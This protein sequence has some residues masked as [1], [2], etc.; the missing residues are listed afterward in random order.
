MYKGDQAQ[1]WYKIMCMVELCTKKQKDVHTTIKCCVHKIG[2][3]GGKAPAIEWS[4][5]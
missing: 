5:T 3:M 2:K 1:Y 4:V